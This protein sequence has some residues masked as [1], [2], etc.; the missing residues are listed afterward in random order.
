M[1]QSDKLIPD[2]AGSHSAEFDNSN[3][4]IIEVLENPP[5]M[6]WPESP[7]VFLVRAASRSSKR[8]GEIEWEPRD[9]TDETEKIRY[10]R[11]NSCARAEFALPGYLATSNLNGCTA[12]AA[13][14]RN[15][16]GNISAFLEHYTSETVRELDEDGEL[17]AANLLG[18]FVGEEPVKVIVAYTKSANPPREARQTYT[19]DEFPLEAI[20]NQCKKLP[21]GSH[22]LLI[23]YDTS[24]DMPDDVGQPMPGS[25]LVVGFAASGRMDFQWNGQRVEVGK[26]EEANAKSILAARALTEALEEEG[27]QEHENMG[28][29]R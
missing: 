20:I 8:T 22:V 6:E 15:P 23:P 26:P 29:V 16:D 5:E 9:L 2:G 13:C 25:V 19:P 3:G 11:M 24:D 12:V 28:D 21:R 4:V 17:K 18:E 27:R 1:T 14:F 10:V 7:M